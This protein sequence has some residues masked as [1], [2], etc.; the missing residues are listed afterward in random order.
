MSDD[1]IKRLLHLDMHPESAPRQAADRIETLMAERAALGRKL[2]TALYGE[3]HFGVQALEARIEALEAER[4]ALRAEIDALRNPPEEY[5]ARCGAPKS[6]H[7][8]RH[9]FVSMTLNREPDT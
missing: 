1:L 4:D 8:Y 6:N 5:C 2:N 9:P 3:P 7:P